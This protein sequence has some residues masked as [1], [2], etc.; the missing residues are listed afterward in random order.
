MAKYNTITKTATRT[1]ASWTNR[2]KAAFHAFNPNGQV[3]E[4]KRLEAI[5]AEIIED[6]ETPYFGYNSHYYEVKLYEM[7]AQKAVKRG[8]LW[9]ALWGLDQ[10]IYQA[11]TYI[12][13]VRT[14]A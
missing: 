8:D 5:I 12:E 11:K 3:A 4:L 1:E 7:C 14:A 9:L 2:Q 6:G 13:Q 10:R